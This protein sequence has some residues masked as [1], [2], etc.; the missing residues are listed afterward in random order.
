[1]A[2]DQMAL[3][4][5]RGSKLPVGE[6]HQHGGLRR[7]V[8]NF[9]LWSI[10]D[11]KTDAGSRSG[12]TYGAMQLLPDPLRNGRAWRCDNL[13]PIAQ[14]TKLLQTIQ[15]LPASGAE[16]E[17]LLLAAAA[18]DAAV[19]RCMSVMRVISLLLSVSCRAT[20]A[21]T[22]HRGPATVSLLRSSTCNALAD[23]GLTW[24]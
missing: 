21:Y 20:P 9:S 15:C 3:Q 2:W 17:K 22:I 7:K 4:Y 18:R 12:N 13:A 6:L 16:A 1:M 11:C 24:T 10:K 14:R 8:H 23:G 5:R 19:K